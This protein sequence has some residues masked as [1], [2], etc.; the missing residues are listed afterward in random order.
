M[1][2]IDPA[3]KKNLLSR[4]SRIEGQIR[5]ISR[6]IEDEQYCI[7]VLN[8]ISAARSALNSV[9]Q[10][11]LEGHIKGCVTD[12]IQHGVGDASIDELMDA[13]KKYTF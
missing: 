4:L 8:Q 2:S 12:A 10:I 9:G 11:M 7:D 3:R 5:G 13:I 1:P 6:M